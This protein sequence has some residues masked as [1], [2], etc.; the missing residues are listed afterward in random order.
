MKGG[1]RLAVFA[2][3]GL[4]LAV[5]ARAQKA[6][7]SLPDTF[8]ERTQVAN[9][10]EANIESRVTDIEMLKAQAQRDG[11]AVKLSCIE[12]KLQKSKANASQARSVMEGW[13]MGA[14]NLLFSQRTLDRLLL[15]QV[16]AMVYAEEARACSDAKALGKALEV[17]IEPSVPPSAGTAQTPNGD[18]GIGFPP[19]RLERPP[20]A[21]PF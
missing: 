7:P 5:A 3:A 12:E 19:P 9:A 17:K 21:S 11:Q 1:A 18:D 4:A 8:E 2:V 16:Y 6:L 20:L 10:T 14:V 15:L 13:A